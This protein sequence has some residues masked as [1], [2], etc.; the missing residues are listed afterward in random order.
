MVVDF[1]RGLRKYFLDHWRGKQ[2][3]ARSVF[4]NTFLPNILLSIADNQIVAQTTDD[5]SNSFWIIYLSAS[6][7]VYLVVAI[8][9]A[10][11]IV[12]AANRVRHDQGMDGAVGLAFLYAP[13]MFGY[14]L[15]TLFHLSVINF[16]IIE[17]EFNLD[18]DINEFEIEVLSESEVSFD[19]G[20]TDQAV[21]ALKQSLI[22]NRDLEIIHLTSIGGYVEAAEKMAELIRQHQLETYV[23]WECASACVTVFVASNYRSVGLEGV[24]GLHASD[25]PGGLLAAEECELQREEENKYFRSRGVAEWFIQKSSDT[26]FN[27]LWEPNFQQLTDASVITHIFDGEN[28]IIAAEYCAKHDC[29]KLPIIEAQDEVSSQ[30]AASE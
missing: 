28:D 7:F 24:F 1:F 22:A 8:W 11:G 21:S 15:W 18:K 3:L 9:Q 14:V 16:R 6:T 29:T 12:R 25:C 17:M 5:T 13:V 19:G 20:I 26:P 23:S 27:E 2:S 30:E 4:I 10:T